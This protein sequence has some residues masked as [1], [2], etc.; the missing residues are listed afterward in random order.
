MPGG[1]PANRPVGANHLTEGARS[2]AEPASPAGCAP[3]GRRSPILEALATPNH[4]PSVLTSWTRTILAALQEKGVDADALVRGAGLDP[5]AFDDPD[6]RFDVTATARLWQGAVEATG[7]PAF[8]LYASRFVNQPTFH[9]LGYAIMASS[10][11]REALVRNVRYGRLVS[12]AA[13]CRLEERGEVASL[14]L[15][16]P[17]D[18]QQP[19]H[20]AM[21]GMICLIARSFRALS[22]GKLN[23]TRVALQRPAPDSSQDAWPKVFRA[24]VVFDADTNVLEYP[25]AELD[26]RLPAGNTELARMNEEVVARYLAR[27]E[28]EH[29]TT[30]VRSHLTEQLSSGEPSAAATAKS[31]GLSQ[32]S[33]QR[34]LADEGTTYKDLLNDTRK[35]LACAYLREGRTSI[36]E[37]A[38]LLGFTDTSSFARA[39]K[40]WTGTS[41]SDYARS[42]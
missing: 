15:D 42:T 40:R 22:G 34:K 1:R 25:A 31:L 7:D 33:L 3:P 16:I 19:A 12:D 29:I 36:T 37:L 38:F 32:R 9:A 2:A 39:F 30:R 8:G 24:P 41:P 5:A 17:K 21:D 13:E 35:D 27:L 18:Q 20:E 28:Q 14:I 23:P 6:A 10:T 11:L 26:T 4:A